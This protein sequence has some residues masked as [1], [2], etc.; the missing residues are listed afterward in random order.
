ME[1]EAVFGGEDDDDD[2]PPARVITAHARPRVSAM[3]NIATFAGRRR[4]RRTWGSA[5]ARSSQTAAAEGSV[6]IE[7]DLEEWPAH[8]PD[9][10]LPER[11]APGLANGEEFGEGG[12]DACCGRYTD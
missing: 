6:V 4:T 9:F 2:A 1:E 3:M 7:E 5:G 10:V 8:Q 11:A 12:A